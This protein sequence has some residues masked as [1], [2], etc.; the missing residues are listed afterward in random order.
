[1]RTTSFPKK[2]EPDARHLFPGFRKKPGNRGRNRLPAR[3]GR[4]RA[5]PFTLNACTGERQYKNRAPAARKKRR[6]NGF[7]V[8]DFFFGN[9]LRL[10]A[11]CK[12]E[13][14]APAVEAVGW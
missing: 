13:V 10:R 3:R 11:S 1:M 9:N 4:P 7:G 8:G 5:F 12:S 6:K 2:H 14:C